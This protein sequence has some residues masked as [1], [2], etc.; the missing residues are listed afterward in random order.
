[1]DL[2]EGYGSSDGDEEIQIPTEPKKFKVQSAPEVGLEEKYLENKLYLAPGQQTMSIN[3][4][5]E[6]L[7][8][9]VLGP[10]NRNK[11]R[12]ENQNVFT[13]VV[14]EQGI[15]EFDFRAQER[16]FRSLG[17]ALNPSDSVEEA[18]YVGNQEQVE[19]LKGNNFL[20]NTIKNNV[21]LKRK[22]KGDPSIVEGEN[23]Y[24]GPWAG[25]EGEKLGVQTGPTDEE[26][27]AYI[28]RNATK[29][30][31]EAE[32]SKKLRENE[33]T[34]TFHGKNERD[35]MGR[36]YMHP[37]VT[38]VEHVNFSGQS[39]VQQCFA[40]KKC[41]HQFSAHG[42]GVSAIRFL[43]KTGHLL[44]SSGMEGKVKI[45]DVYGSHSLLRTFHGHTKAVRDVTFNNDGT[46]FL[47]TSYDK[48]VKLWDTE[49]G[50]CL[51]RFSSGKVPY[52]SRLNPSEQ[53][54][55]IT[56]Q[57]DKKII[58]YDIRTKEKVLEY[59]EHLGAISTLA[60][61]DNGRR[62]VSTSDDKTMRVW[63]FGLPVV[64]KLIA[65]PS[66]HAIPAIA[67]HPSNK[68]IACQSLDNQ[69]LVW[70]VGDRFKQNRKKVFTGH[71][72][73]GYACQLSFS[74]DGSYL[75][76]GDA[77]GKLW[78]WDWKTCKVVKRFI[79]HKN[80]VTIDAE[81][82]PVEASK[83]ATCSWDGTIKFWD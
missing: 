80:A 45:W 18:K 83:V 54:L 37:P 11:K 74:P 46:R 39:E 49:T 3:L 58:Q 33:E 75:T 12:R 72:S 30:L 38:E 44:L 81:W 40:P 29:E 2:V 7:S 8:Q 71:L 25:Y 26:K 4:T 28:A 61:V 55:F 16:S 77:D 17:F 1:M 53:N 78:V 70:G 6:V 69:V 57:A 35:Y 82:S 79:A 34:T 14:E 47:S 9:P 13:G 22:A 31:G 15:S 5:H 36:S 10:E 50:Q 66:M 43:P 32:T 41:I 76:S 24:L 48:Y 42:K 73:A 23:A 67:L 51:N 62:F 68:F 64:I 59:S 20:T 27:A 19:R 63:E 52:V 56:G 65:D 21:D 60:F